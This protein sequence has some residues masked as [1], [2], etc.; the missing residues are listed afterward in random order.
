M[1]TALFSS[2][3]SSPWLMG[4]IWYL[5]SLFFETLPSIGLQDTESSWFSPLWLFLLHL[6][7][8]LRLLAGSSST[9]HLSSGESW[10]QDMQLFSTCTLFFPWWPLALKYPLPVGKSQMH[11]FSLDLIPELNMQISFCL[12]DR[13]R[14]LTSTSLLR[15]PMLN[16]KP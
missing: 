11:I 6:L 14:C 8:L 2:Q 1:S 4:S 5:H 3:V 10:A 12:L 16:P 13:P 9:H 7:F 15:H